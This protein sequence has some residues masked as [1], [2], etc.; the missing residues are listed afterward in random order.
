MG[1]VIHSSAPL[2]ACLAS[3]L[4]IIPIYLLRRQPNLREGAT[5]V[6][7]FVKLG[8]VLT[9]VA[10]VLDGKVVEYTLCE[11][12]PGV[13]IAF[14]VDGLGALFALVASSLWIVTSLYSVGYMRGLKEHAQTR[15]YS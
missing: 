8:I 15:Y 6:A 7:G 1:E 12:V 9:I 14:R 10:P 4:A 13:P 11:L 2:W 3:L 5:F